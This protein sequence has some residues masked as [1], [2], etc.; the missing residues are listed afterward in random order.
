MNMDEH[1]QPLI[2][3]EQVTKVY[4]MGK[5]DVA[6]LRG[7]SFTIWPGEFVA[8][9]GASGSG[10]TTLMNIIGCLDLPTEGH[11]L[12]NGHDVSDYGDRRLSIMRGKSIGFVFQNYSLLRQYSALHNVQMPY[13]Y[14]TG[15]GDR[16]RAL[17]L[18]EQVGLR[19]RARHRPTEMSGGEQQRV[20]IARALM[21]EPALLLADEPTGNL[22]STTGQEI[23]TLLE[24]LN[25]QQGLTLVVVTHDAAVSSRARRVITLH[26]GRVVDDRHNQP[27]QDA[28]QHSFST[29]QRRRT[30]SSHREN[31]RRSASRGLTLRD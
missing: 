29:W 20:A 4:A 3:F 17:A 7:V 30:L 18:L 8:I 1:N 5:V 23:I 28:E 9:I 27:T 14:A 13:Y 16:K 6:A 31:S 15:H 12:I 11:Y 24:K 25:E 21:N 22:D 19:D 10:K 2:Q 26:D